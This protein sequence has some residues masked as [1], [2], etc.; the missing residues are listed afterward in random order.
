MKNTNRYK[1]VPMLI[2]GL[3]ISALNAMAEV[4]TIFSVGGQDRPSIKIKEGEV[5]T[6][7]F[8]AV[9]AIDIIKTL[10]NGKKTYTYILN[11]NNRHEDIFNRYPNFK[12]AGPVEI[13]LQTAGILSMEITPN[14]KH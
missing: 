12:I 8:I 6:C 11:G 3:V 13:Q 5:G 7:V 2:I 1:L 14:E 10:A 9:D 4:K